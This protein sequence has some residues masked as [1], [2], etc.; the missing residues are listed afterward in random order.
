[1][2]GCCAK[3]TIPSRPSD[4]RRTLS[5]LRLR[6][7]IIWTSIACSLA[8]GAIAIR[9]QPTAYRASARLLIEPS[10]RSVTGLP[11]VYDPSIGPDAGEVARMEFGETQRA[12]LLSEP[13]LRDTFVRL[14]LGVGEA[15]DASGAFRR[16]AERFSAV[17]VGETRLVEVR[18]EGDDPERA[19]AAVG[20]VVSAA[21]DA[22]RRRR[23][24][25]AE[26]GIAALRKKAEDLR[27]S[28]EVRAQALQAFQIEHGILSLEGSQD[29]IVERMKA[30]ASEL[31]RAEARRIEAAS[32]LRVMQGT[33]VA[34]GSAPRE[35]LAGDP[36][37]I[38]P[39]DL[40]TRGTIESLR[41]A[42]ATAERDLAGLLDRLG[43]NHPATRAA[44]ANLD[45]L[46]RRL[47]TETER[48]VA[49]AEADWRRARAEEE[50]IRRALAE[51]E[52]KVRDLNRLAGMY[53]PLDESYRTAEATHKLVVSRIEEIEVAKA[54]DRDENIFVVEP[55]TAEPHPVR[56]RRLA[57]LAAALFA[58]LVLGLGLCFLLDHLDGTI[59]DADAA[60][61]IVGARVLARVPSWGAAIDT[62]RPGWGDALVRSPN[63]RGLFGEAFALLRAALSR[64]D[65]CRQA[66][67]LLVTSPERGDG[68]SAAALQLSIALARQGKMVALIDA[69]LRRPALG[70]AFGNAARRFEGLTDILRSNESMRLEDVLRPTSVPKLFIIPAGRSTANPTDLLASSS[71]PSLLDEIAHRFDAVVIDGPPGADGAGAAILSAATDATLI[72][73]RRLETTGD[74]TARLVDELRFAEGRVVGVVLNEAGR[75]RPVRLGKPGVRPLATN[76]SPGRGDRMNIAGAG[77]PCGVEA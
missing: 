46:E 68:K 38:A 59:R 35:P 53:R 23:S 24:E 71:L 42:R 64:A 45:A 9:L 74:R 26:K 44:Q 13:V 1:M 15:G 65:V 8:A 5:V 4:L 30:L 69:N 21:L 19:A 37:S 36:D 67:T 62:R 72:V 20:A 16:F 31:T 17:A 57:I 41:V 11:S 7:W 43:S 70:H 47:A 56:P 60:S 48:V 51:Q 6:H 28:M 73:L 66:T 18:F 2:S 12:L 63:Q 27:R 75:V 29:T 77:R 61:A 39:A 49:R 40:T 10:R 22:S 3:T 58:G 14:G 33:D 32:R 76:P 55:A 34:G 52:S 54:A 25:V 50:A